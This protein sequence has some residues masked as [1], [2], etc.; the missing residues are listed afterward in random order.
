MP[1]LI[2]LS[3]SGSRLDGK[4]LH[5]A[6]RQRHPRA[7]CNSAAVGRPS[8]AGAGDEPE[9]AAGQRGE[10]LGVVGRS[11]HG[12][13]LQDRRGSSTACWPVVSLQLRSG[14]SCSQCAPDRPSDARWNDRQNDM[15]GVQRTTRSDRRVQA[16]AVA[17]GWTPA[18]VTRA[19][20]GGTFPSVLWE[21]FGSTLEVDGGDVLPL[22]ILVRVALQP[23][24][25]RPHA[26]GGDRTPGGCSAVGRVGA[27][28]PIAGFPTRSR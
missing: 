16:E 28:R 6:T 14:A 2:A 20:V 8:L 11:W 9:A 18:E 26:F 23:Q 3:T 19:G 5:V 24:L 10:G 7:T 25:H 27:R 4:R 17:V 1:G 21:M 13:R 15:S 12:S 22:R